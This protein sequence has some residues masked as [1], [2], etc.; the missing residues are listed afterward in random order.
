MKNGG[1][2]LG[3]NNRR[4]KNDQ[5]IWSGFR[6]VDKDAGEDKDDNDNKSGIQPLSAQHE[7]KNHKWLMIIIYINIDHLLGVIPA[8]SVTF[9]SGALFS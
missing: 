8:S 2:E 5:R 6:W 9:P 4:R 7:K 1:R 3:R